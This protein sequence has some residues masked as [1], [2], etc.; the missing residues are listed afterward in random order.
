MH[1]TICVNFSVESHRQTPGGTSVQNLLLLKKDGT[2]HKRPKHVQVRTSFLCRYKS[3]LLESKLGIY[4]CVRKS[5]IQGAGLGV[6]ASTVLPK[7]F[8][9]PYMGKMYVGSF[10]D[11]SM[12]I[13]SQ[14][15]HKKSPMSYILHDED[16]RTVIDGHPSYNVTK[17]N[18]G[19]RIN[20]PPKGTKANTVFITSEKWAKRFSPVSVRTRRV[21]KENEELFVYYGDSYDRSF[22]SV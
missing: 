1:K 7:G 3:R 16:T 22:Y 11:A 13:R 5:T 9:I 10:E 12:L 2:P 18:V 17:H 15:A 21:I 19:F 14:N 8:Q 6:F 4:V 20:E